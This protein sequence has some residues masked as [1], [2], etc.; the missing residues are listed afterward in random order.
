M[1]ATTL[2]ALSWPQVGT[3]T[4]LIPLGSVEQHGPHLPLDTDTRIAQALAERV[5]T[6]PDGSG[7]PDTVVAPAL[8]YG[9]SGEHEGFPGT[10]SIGS[11]ALRDVVIEI[12]RSAT[13]TFARV[14]LVC[15]HGG[16]LD[17]LRAALRTL[18]AER[19]EVVAWFTAVPGGD[20]HAGRTETSLMLALAPHLVRP[21]PWPAG[22]ATPLP[23][24]MPALRQAGVA[25]VSPTGILGDPAGAC[26]G[27]GERILRRLIGQ[28]R[29]LTA[30]R[31]RATG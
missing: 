17:G 29:P 7:S 27:D 5:A 14:L 10:I 1:S 19:R 21:G 3:G 15:G 23:R 30:P 13:R 28:L 20:P 18:Q 8:A 31:Q 24:L 16:N 9:A 11:D 22:P 12:V 25:G 2:G 26:A 4:V 6:G